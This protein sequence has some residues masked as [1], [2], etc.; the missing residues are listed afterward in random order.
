M[1]NKTAFLTMEAIILEVV[2]NMRRGIYDLKE[3]GVTDPLELAKEWVST[4]ISNLMVE[5]D[6]QDYVFYLHTT[7]KEQVL[8]VG[9]QQE[10]KPEEDPDKLFFCEV[11]RVSLASIEGWAD[12][13]KPA[14]RLFTESELMK[15]W[16]QSK[17]STDSPAY[18]TELVNQKLK[19]RWS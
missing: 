15:L 5:R 1:K 6:V 11:V 4:H 9:I 8:V 16:N 12:K 2:T 10:A 17:E 18:F 3:Q 13:G 7:A 19:E 14:T